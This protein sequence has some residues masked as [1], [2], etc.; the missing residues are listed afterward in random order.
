MN[1]WLDNWSVELIARCRL[2]SDPYSG[3]SVGLARASSLLGRVQLQLVSLHVALHA[4]SKD[5]LALYGGVTAT[6]P[7]S[8]HELSD[9]ILLEAL[10]CRRCGDHNVTPAF[11]CNVLG[12][13][14]S[15]SRFPGHFVKIP[16]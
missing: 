4:L 3:V 13:P 16:L 11:V 10:K 12:V 9:V 14:Q 1:A 2:D 5:T 6:M 7:T 15:L 8:V